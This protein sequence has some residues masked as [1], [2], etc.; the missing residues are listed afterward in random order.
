MHSPV[1]QTL[2]ITEKE[3]ARAWASIDDLVYVDIGPGEE[4]LLP[5]QFHGVAQTFDVGGLLATYQHLMDAGSP[6]NGALQGK[7][8]NSGTS[9]T[10]YAQMSA[11]ASTPIA[12]LMEQFH[13]FVLAVLNKKMKNIVSFYDTDR[14]EKIAGRI[15]TLY[16][17]SAINLNEIADLE[18]DLRIKESAD[19]PVFREMQEQD[20]LTF[21][22]GREKRV[23]ESAHRP[24][25]MG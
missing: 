14:F 10:L 3:F 25:E 24:K 16:D 20:L 9:G 1:V 19:T 21:L 4:E 13:N 5:K 15:D 18:Y 23:F 17:M 7:T 2:P 11:N 22:S 6:V 12:A 8:P